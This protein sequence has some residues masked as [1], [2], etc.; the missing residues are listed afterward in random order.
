MSVLLEFLDLYPVINTKRGYKGGMMAFFDFL[1]GSQRK[2]R[3]ATKEEWERYEALSDRYSTEKRD[4]INDLMMFNASNADIP[5][6]TAKVRYNAVKEFYAFCGFDMSPREQKRVR[7]KLPK[8]SA[9]TIEK[10][11]DHD[12]LHAII[13]H[14][15]IKSKAMTLTLA[16]SGMRI[17]EL[18][19]LNITDFDLN[20]GPAVVTIRGEYTK[21]GESRFTFISKEAVDALKEWLKVREKYMVSAA[22]RNRAF[23]R[24]ERAKERLKHDNRMFP[25]SQK[26]AGEIWT[27]ALKNAGYL[28][29]DPGTGRSQIHIHMLRKFFRSQLALACPVDIVEA[30]MGHSGYLTNAYR[31]FTKKQMGEYYQKA[32]HL[33][34]IQIPKELKEIESEFKARMQNHSDIIENI[35]RENIVLKQEITKIKE[36]QG[37]IQVTS[38]LLRVLINDNPKAQSIFHEL[39]NEMK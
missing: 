32:E 10:D 23:V 1:Y 39:V 16:S 15:D 27:N 7:A 19:Q 33:V 2:A 18:V 31:R 14:M 21:T 26:N 28:T 20:E 9:R 25:F 38:E 3:Q 17:G 30:L 8:G 22:N 36:E 37:K 34:T 35:V 29:Y 12:T 4:L 13:Q 11:M 24:R 6:L 5:P